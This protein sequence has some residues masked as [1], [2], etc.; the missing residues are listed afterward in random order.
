[1]DLLAAPNDARLVIESTTEVEIGAQQTSRVAIPVSALVGSGESSV[2]LKLRT[3]AG[4]EIGP[5]ETI[6]VSVRA[7][8][9]A[10]S[11]I[12]LSVLVSVLL[13]FGV[14][15]TVRRRRRMPVDA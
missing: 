8:W 6:N 1:M 9:E 15:R 3:P 10:V 4:V 2:D 13:V 7:E 11:I 5:T 12:I 14:V